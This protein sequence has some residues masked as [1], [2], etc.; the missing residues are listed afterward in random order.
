MPHVACRSREWP[1]SNPC[2]I[3]EAQEIGG[4]PGVVS[5]GYFS[6]DKQRKLSRLSVREPTLKPTV[7]LATQDAEVYFRVGTKTVPTLAGF[8][9]FWPNK[10]RN[11]AAG[12]RPDIKTRRGNSSTFVRL[13][14]RCASLC[15]AHYGPTALKSSLRPPGRVVEHPPQMCGKDRPKNYSKNMPK[16]RF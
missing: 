7:A 15:S 8:G 10:K 5:F 12:P 13:R 9:F 16:I 3:R 1:S 14:D 6:L 2:Q 4:M 11:S